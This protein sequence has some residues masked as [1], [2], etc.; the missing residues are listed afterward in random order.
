[1]GYL[2]NDLQVAYSTY[3]NID[4]ISGSF[5]GSTTSFSLLVGGVAPVP[6]PLN[7]Q[8]C[9]ISVGGVIQRPDDTGAEGFRLS[10]GN[11]VFSSAPSTGEDFFGVI[12]AGAD[13]VN[14]GANFPSGSAAVPSIT[15]DS[16]LD[17]GI[18]NSAANQVSITTAGT[19][20]LRITSAGNVGIGTTSPGN[21]LH[22]SGTGT[23]CQ[24]A[25]SNN[26]NLINLKGNGATNGVWLGTT[27]SD[28]FVISSG[29][30]VTERARIDSSGRLLVGTSSAR[31]WA[32][33]TSQ[34]QV[35]GAATFVSQS[36][37]A[38]S[39][40]TVGGLLT[41]G[42]SRG[43]ALGS[44]T[45]VQSGDI[46]GRIYFVGA[47]GSAL[48]Q[49]AT[50]TAEV[51]GTPGA[52][53]MP[54]RLVFSTTADGASSPTERMRIDSFG[55][56]TIGGTNSR[57]L[58][59]YRA[60]TTAGSEISTW[61]SD[62]GGTKT[63]RAYFRNDGG[64]ANFSANNVNLSDRN[65]KKDI[66]LAADT[67]NYL[68]E[69]EIVNFRYKD[70]PDDSDLNMGVIAQQVAESC[71]EV[72]TVFQEATEDKPEKLGVKDQQMMWMAIKALQEAQV[73]IETLEAEVAA[74]KAA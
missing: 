23:V 16:D 5:N 72:I 2:G 59:V 65:A 63:A 73:R 67:W 70:Q 7:S 8:Q 4:D 11:I 74:L 22:V 48:I 33:I 46:L 47:D 18:Y 42:K 29:A 9:L 21:L 19:E 12:L 52:N 54:G 39:A 58:D 25:S 1:M 62:I 71:P 69:W 24:L 14:V 30:S 53:D 3:K 10:S 35:E 56:V 43:T 27:S 20:R 55:L 6:L 36:I 13:Y 44:H 41:L 60:G 17:T 51:D 34:T 37:V 28:D 40:D 32:G 31:S 45:I 61:Y 57:N 49:G 38:N 15:F 66:A 26:N 50:I 68:K 64:L